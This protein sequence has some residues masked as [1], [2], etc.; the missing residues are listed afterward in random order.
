MR[1]PSS[2]AESEVVSD[3]LMLTRVSKSYDGVSVLEDVSMSVAPGQVHAILGENGAGKSTLMS[4]ISGD[5]RA[6]GGRV[7]VAGHDLVEASPAVANEYGVGVVYQNP[8]LLDDLSVWENLALAVAKQHLPES[9]NLI[10]WAEERISVVDARI[11]PRALVADLL[12]VDREW[13]EIAKALSIDLKLLILDEPTAVMGTA[14]T[15]TLFSIIRNLAAQGV[16]ILYISHRIPEIR[17]IADKV[18]I[19]RDGR[20]QGVFDVPSVGDADML[21]LVAGRQLAA[22]LPARTTSPG[23]VILRCED[24]SSRRLGGVN[25]EVRAGE[26]LGLGG[27]VGNGQTELIRVLA[28]LEQSG[29]RVIYQGRELRRR[30]SKVR[31]AGLVYIS[32]DRGGEGIFP[33]L[34][35]RKNT[36]AEALRSF[37]SL[38][39]VNPKEERDVANVALSRLSVRMPGHNATIDALSGGSQQK[40]VFSRA[41][42]VDPGVLLCDEPT[43]GIDIASRLEIYELLRSLA[44]RGVAIV[45]VSSDTAELAQL[46]D[47]VLV[48]SRGQIA[49]ELVG[50]AITGQAITGQAMT[51]RSNVVTK[52]VGPA[53]VRSGTR[54]VRWL[55]GGTIASLMLLVAIVVVGAVTSLSASSYLSS[56]NL[57]SVFFLAAILVLVSLGELA[58]LLTGGIDLAVG[59][60]M[61]VTIVVMSFFE[62]SANNLE[63]QLLGV[64]AVLCIG[65]AVGLFHTLLIRVLK[66]APIITTVITYIGLQGVAL[67]MRP[68]PGGSAST[69]F[70][71]LF[72]VALGPIPV[73]FLIAI[74]A[75]VAWEIA[76][77]RTRFGMALRAVGSNARSSHRVGVRVGR[78]VLYAYVI[79]AVMAVL[80][81][82][83]L[84]AQVG[85]G[86][87]SVGIN[88]SLDAIAAVVLGGASVYGGRGS[89]I[90]AAL[91]AILL[92][93]LDGVL[94]F[95]NL[96]QAWQYWFPGGLIVLAGFGFSHLVGIGRA[97]SAK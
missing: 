63:S 27:A 41:L 81:G 32:H 83:L 60:L 5:I 73:V 22:G 15:M 8:A 88:Y 69:G 65:L 50:Q 51:A 87:P 92:S 84:Y 3:T 13:L 24:I 94:S 96:S 75:T 53:A 33:G 55:S 11:N 38:G 57:Q 82:I 52:D 80:A 7:V 97:K 58:P 18:T 40:V 59:P 4:I 79:S 42:L 12:P 77:R 10:E 37:A 16:A 39:F 1:D 62:S 25:F 89:F 72:N 46:C 56:Y 30:P 44:D 31:K 78:V 61:A 93:Q 9:G 49:A 28:G 45:V 70:V 36:T 91:G 35:V 66:L 19:L 67:I 74:G 21:A 29:G 71:S 54:L 90:G 34:S 47:R 43:Q 17:E 64:V 76:L 85:I 14:E 2:V 95:L 6:D 20:V 48:F 26:I 23:D 86:D 68:T